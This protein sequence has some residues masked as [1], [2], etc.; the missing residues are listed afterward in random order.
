MSRGPA[1]ACYRRRKPASTVTAHRKRGRAP[2]PG[3]LRPEMKRA[4]TQET[5]LR[6]GAKIPEQGSDSECLRRDERSGDAWK[7][8]EER[9][10]HT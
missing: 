9:E 2:Q 3:W 4:I 8:R 7:M 6:W 10:I 1:G 5:M